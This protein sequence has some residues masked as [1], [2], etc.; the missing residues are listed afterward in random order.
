MDV[1]KFSKKLGLDPL[2]DDDKEHLSDNDQKDDKD[3]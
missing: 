3:I 2:N 1:D